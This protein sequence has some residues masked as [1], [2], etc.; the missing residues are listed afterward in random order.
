MRL[1]GKGREDAPAHEA[2]TDAETDGGPPDSH[3]ESSA[4][5]TGGASAAPE[6]GAEAEEDQQPAKEEGRAAKREERGARKEKK[7]QRKEEAEGR[8]R[9]GKEAAQKVKAGSDAVRSRIA[10]VVWLLAVVAALIL[11]FGALLTAMNAANQQND[12][13]AFITDSADTLAG[14]LGN[15]FEFS[16]QDR[17]AARTKRVLVNWGIAAIVYLVVGKVLDRIIRP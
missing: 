13:V 17:D 16:D 1:R 8:R 14:P 7:E 12:I 5:T 6:Q 10:S 4:G 11:A 9:K 3:L 15:L 2:G